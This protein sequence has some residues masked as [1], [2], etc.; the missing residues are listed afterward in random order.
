MPVAAV[1]V[2]VHTGLAFRPKRGDGHWGSRWARG[3][4]CRASTRPQKHGAERRSGRCAWRFSGDTQ[5]FEFRHGGEFQNSATLSTFGHFKTRTGIGL[6]LTTPT[7]NLTERNTPT[8]LCALCRTDRSELPETSW[9]Y[10]DLGGCR[11]ASAWVRC[12]TDFLRGGIT[13][14]CHSPDPGMRV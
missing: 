3:G 10:L 11:S 7:G 2:A 4:A 9:L 6:N 12:D 13:V 1:C 14:H 8:A 5:E